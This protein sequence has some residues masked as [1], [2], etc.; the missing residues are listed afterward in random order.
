MRQDRGVIQAG[1]GSSLLIQGGQFIQHNYP[2]THNADDVF[3][4]LKPYVAPTAYATQQEGDAPKCHPRT[5]EAVLNAIM[6]WMTI[7]ITGIQRILWLNGAA[8]AGKSAIAR[9]I[10]DLCLKQQIVIARFFFFRTDSARNHTKPLVATFAYQLITLIPA[11][12]PIILDKIRSDPLIFNQSLEHQFEALVFEPLRQLHGAIPFKQVIVLLLDGVDECGGYD[13]QVNVIRTIAQFVAEKSVPLIVIFSS[14]VESQLKMAF[15]SPKIDC[16]LERLPLDTDY[17]AADDIRHFL[18]DSFT[19]IKHTH[20]FKSSIEHDWPTPSLVQEIV[21]KSSMQFI[22]ASVVVKF[23]SSPRFHPARQLDIIR[24]LRPAGDLTPFAQLDALYR[25]IFSQVHDIDSVIAILAVAI[26]SR[27]PFRFHIR[28]ML[29]IAQDDIDVTLVDLGSVIS[30]DM[31]KITFLHA[32]LPDFLLDPARS[33]Q[34]FYIDVGIWGEKLALTLLSKQ[35]FLRGWDALVPYLTYAKCTPRLMKE[36][37]M[38]HPSKYTDW[39]IFSDDWTTFINTVGNMDF[40]DGGA[41]YCHHVKL[42]H[43]VEE[44]IMPEAYQIRET[45]LLRA[46]HTPRKA[47]RW[48]RFKICL[49]RIFH[50]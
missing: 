7:A 31:Q 14:R 47:L 13:N 1:N 40:G 35:E 36:L 6:T 12:N 17:R 10:V 48:A 4:R 33:G 23:V 16:I 19:E 5:R 49:Y 45:A 15:N 32:S 30:C 20:P 39:H 41:L 50:R 22:Y 43:Q 26:L 25:H 37:Y 42:E 2:P 8:G 11:L 46:V 3:N 29:D 18:D 21:D 34:R 44:T 9:S 27:Y 24:G 38:F 28:E